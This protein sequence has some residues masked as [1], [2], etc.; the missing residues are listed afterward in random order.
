M[1]VCIRL[2]VIYVKLLKP[3][4]NYS[5]HGFNIKKCIFCPQSAF[6]CFVWI[7]EKNRDCYLT[8]HSKTDFYIRERM[9]LLRGRKWNFKINSS[10]DHSLKSAVI[11]K[12]YGC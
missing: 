10:Y 9:C 6:M 3:S 8:F 12:P 7:S 4:G 5:H 2:I 11:G 1:N